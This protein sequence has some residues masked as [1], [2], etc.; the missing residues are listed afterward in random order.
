MAIKFLSTVAVDTNVL[1]VDAAANKV[2]IGTASPSQKLTVE[3]DIAS[4]GIYVDRTHESGGISNPFAKLGLHY[5]W[6]DANSINLQ[7]TGNNNK[8]TFS[9]QSGYLHVVNSSGAKVQ[10]DSSEQSIKSASGTFNVGVAQHAT[11]NNNQGNYISITNGGNTTGSR[12]VINVNGDLKINDYSTSS[13]IEKIKL[14]NDGS[15]Y[16]SGNVGIG[17]TTPGEKLEVAG[18]MNLYN[19]SGTSQINLRNIAGANYIK[20]NGYS[21]N[22]GLRGNTGNGVFIIEDSFATT[23]D[24]R[25]KPTTSGWDFSSR[26]VAGVNA[27]LTIDGVLNVSNR[28]NVGIGTTSPLNKLQVSGGSVGIDSQYM[29]RDNRNNTILQQ[30][31]NTVTSNRSLT[32][33]NATYSDVI[34]PNG[35][36]GIGTTSPSV[37]L[38]V[39]QSADNQGLKILGFD[40]E[41]NSNLHFYVD[42]FGND[43]IT[44]S[45]FLNITS[46]GSSSYT[47]AGYLRLRGGG[48][49]SQIELDGTVIKFTV[50]S[51]EKM[52]LTSTGLGIGTTAPTAKLQIDSTSGWGVFTERGIKD[53]STSTYSH[54]YSAGNAH[55]L[56]RAMYFENSAVF[57]TSTADATTKEYRFSNASDKLTVKSLVAGNT[58]DDNILVLS[59]SNVGIGI[60]SPARTLDVAGRGRFVD[61]TGIVDICSSAYVPLLI[62]NTNGYAHARINGFEV[63]GNTTAN[64]EGYIKTS[65]NSRKL[66]LDTNGWRF[67]AQSA[68]LMRI[69]SSGNVGIG[70]TSPSTALHIKSTSAGGGYATIENTVHLAKLQLKSATY[71]GSLVMDGTGGY[72]SGGG[73]ILDSGTHPKTQFLQGGVSKMIINNG[74]VGIGTASPS[75]K[76]DVAGNAIVRGDIVSRDTYPS[77]YVDHSGTV[78]GGIRADATNKL[79]L[80]TLTTAPL[81]FQVNSSE[82]MRVQNNGNVGIG[83]TSPTR[84]LDIA[85]SINGLSIPL[86]VRNTYS[87]GGRTA[88]IGFAVTS[89]DQCYGYVG[90][91]REQPTASDNIM[92]FSVASQPSNSAA[93]TDEKMFI[94]S[95]GRVG[96]GVAAPSETLDVNGHIKL[97]GGVYVSGANAFVWNST[98]NSNLRFGASGSEK[99]RITSAGNLGI[100]TT[101]PSQKLEVD[102]EVLSDGYRVSAMQ[103][104]PAARNSTGTLGEIRITSNYIYV[105]YA[106]NSWSR[107]ALATS[108]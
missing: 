6:G 102:G 107:V 33:G 10:I 34:I 67:L 62:T 55:I 42:N 45:E 27:L 28:T 66:I 13:A 46:G 94:T 36:V 26:G 39:Q 82:K 52:R 9:T 38:E 3:G 56:G 61:S 44:S 88:A 101:S 71:T 53:G 96:I 41:N 77:I 1:Y 12:G 75:E 20:S 50:S 37:A 79:E 22:F 21:T 51:S 103:T 104:A 90:V 23:Q 16:F 64:N 72:I 7:K 89:A 43:R 8:F 19:P 73:L 70:T 92:A 29:V 47:A 49:T 58:F 54:N 4:Q 69:T 91:R 98:A 31:A 17:T 106:T 5:F 85:E 105:C 108:W 78:M 81:S 74:D 76:L 18:D 87:G 86:M 30:S 65:D 97:N 40:N 99:M 15:A 95:T 32:I 35:N 100:G 24:I 57:S 80:K 83:T 63:G 14:K 48:T 11:A 84:K 2:G 93:T 68:E 59:G 60:A 25:I